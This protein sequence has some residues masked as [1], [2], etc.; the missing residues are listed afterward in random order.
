MK[1]VLS[2]IIILIFFLMSGCEREEIVSPVDDGLPPAPPANL[3]IFYAAEGQIG[4]DWIKESYERVVKY[5]IYKSVNDTAG[6]YFYDSTYEV[7]YIDEPLDY[8]SLYFYKVKAIDRQERE[9]RFSSTVSAKPE[10]IYSPLPPR[11]ININGQNIN[12]PPYISLHWYPNN[13]P[14]IK[15]YE[16]YRSQSENFGADSSTF[17]T[18]HEKNYYDDSFNLQLLTTYFYRIIAVDKGGLKSEP[19][20]IRGD[21]VLDKPEVIFPEDNSKLKN[22]SS[23]KIRTASHPVRYELF[24]Q[25]AG[26]Y[27]TY[28]RIEFTSDVI[29][30]EIEISFDSGRLKKYVEYRFFVAAYTKNSYNSISNANNFTLID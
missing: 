24:I 6:F 26:V 12:H 1:K 3:S 29:N 2:P 14:D 18:F 9:S 28:S 4:L 5:K 8:D 11:D 17:L 7:Y 30:S 27:Q 13:D 22:F 21:M 19:S 10:N 16:I 15:G 20:I 23:F 25:E